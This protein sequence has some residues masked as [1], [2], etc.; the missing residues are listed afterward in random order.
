MNITE[1]TGTGKI[2]KLY[3]GSCDECYIGSTFE[4]YISNRLSGHRR[5]YK[6]YKNGKISWVT[7]FKL[8]EKDSDVQIIELERFENITKSQL[9]KHELEHIKLNPNCVNKYHPTRSKKD[10]YIDNKDKIREHYI[11]NKDKI[12]EYYINNKDKINQKFVCEICGG[13]YTRQNKALHERSKK[14][15]QAI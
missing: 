4:K 6:R 13:R 11:D 2:Y 12:K 10:Y 5:A 7:S 3:I 15:K 14:H 8:F 9:E 1:K